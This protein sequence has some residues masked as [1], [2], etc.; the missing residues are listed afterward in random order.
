MSFFRRA[1]LYLARKK[2]RTIL[3]F[4]ILVVVITL[5]LLCLT[6][7]HGVDIAAERLG[8][9]GMTSEDI[10]EALPEAFK[11]ITGK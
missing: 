11:R 7:G 5:V 1:L 4:F 3:L 8:Q 10:A 9:R 2:Q 6:A